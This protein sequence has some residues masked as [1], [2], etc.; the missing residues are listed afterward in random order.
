LAA[1]SK[2]RITLGGLAA[3]LIANFYHGGDYSG[4]PPHDINRR[5][6]RACLQINHCNAVEGRRL[7]M[8]HLN[9]LEL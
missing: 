4:A 8:C 7:R 3:T 5:S 9:E 6:A 2:W 1:G